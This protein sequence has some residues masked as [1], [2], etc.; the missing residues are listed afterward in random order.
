MQVQLGDF[1]ALNALWAAMTALVT[2]V[3][4]LAQ[5]RKTAREEWANTA[6]DWKA[7]AEASDRRVDVLQKQVDQLQREIFELTITA[8]RLEK[9]NKRLGV[10]N[11]DLQDDVDRLARRCKQLERVMVQAGISVPEPVADDEE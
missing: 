3:V 6:N 1:S 8:E 5:V 11:R 4:L 7:S 9:D 10:R 2:G